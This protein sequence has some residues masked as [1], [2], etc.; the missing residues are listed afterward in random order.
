MHI[1][2]KRPEDNAEVFTTILYQE[3]NKLLESCKFW[4]E[5]KLND[6]TLEYKRGTE[7]RAKRGMPR[8][9]RS[10]RF[11][12]KKNSIWTLKTL[13]VAFQIIC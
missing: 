2:T 6:V 4:S 9:V 7:R 13:T 1:P 8:I 5:M 11:A 10:S 3:I 12:T